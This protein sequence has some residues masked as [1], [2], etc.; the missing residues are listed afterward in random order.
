MKKAFFLLPII[1]LSSC[2]I[3]SGVDGGNLEITANHISSTPV[4]EMKTFKVEGHTFIYYN[5]YNDGNGNF[6]M[7]DNSS[8]ISNNSI[9]FGLR[10]K[11]M[12][13]YEINKNG[14]SKDPPIQYK[15]LD[16]YGYYSYSIESFGFEIYGVSK[17]ISLE[18]KDINIGKIYHW[19]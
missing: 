8:F 18:Y 19:C 12:W 2:R 4:K 5:V 3:N 15:Y 14:Y 10:V 6:V 7:A 17:S 1:L 9:Q 11:S 13:V 16:E